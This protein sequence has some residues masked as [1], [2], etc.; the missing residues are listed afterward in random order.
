MNPNTEKTSL[1]QRLKDG[2]TVV[3]TWLQSGS[4]VAAG[5]HIVNPNET[6]VKRALEIAAAGGHNILLIGPPGSG[7]S[8]LAKRIP[9]ILPEMSRQEILDTYCRDHDRGGHLS[10]LRT[11]LRRWKRRFAGRHGVETDG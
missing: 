2:K 4:A 10:G 1:R 6:N 3:G 8:M 5:Q 7:K 11:K 9:T